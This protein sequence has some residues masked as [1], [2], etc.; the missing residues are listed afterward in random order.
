[1]RRTNG[2]REWRD[3][4]IRK[5]GKD[6]KQTKEM[7]VRKREREGEKSHGGG[8]KSQEAFDRR[9]ENDIRAVRPK[10][11]NDVCAGKKERAAVAEKRRGYRP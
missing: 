4:G 5:L 7:K 9:R 1:M 10:G 2:K 8:G 6:E 11:M 3:E